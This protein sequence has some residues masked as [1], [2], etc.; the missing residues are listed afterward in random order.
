MYSILTMLIII[1]AVLLVTVI[2]LQPGKGQL[3]ATFGG[4]SSQFGAV[5]GMQRANDL[6]ARV[7]KWIAAII[8]FFVLMTNKF[9]VGQPEA[10]QERKRPVTEGAEVPLNQQPSLTPPPAQQPGAQPMAPPEGQVQ[11]TPKPQPKE[12]QE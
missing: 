2:L 5:F 6:L 1:G 12:P 4:I 3:S 9:F 7:T 11:T 8:L 10:T